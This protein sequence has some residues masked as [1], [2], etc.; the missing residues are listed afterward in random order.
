M[1]LLNIVTI[2]DIHLGILDPEY[3][4][5]NLKDYFF[6]YCSENKPDIIVV[7][8]DITDE[9]VS[10]NSTTASVFHMFI[11]ELVKLDTIIVIV[12]GTL[13]HDDNQINIFSHRICDKFRIYSKCTS[14][15]ILGLKMLFIP[16]EY[17][18][19]PDEYYKEFLDDKNSYDCVFGHGMFNHIAFYNKKKNIFRKLT[20]PMWDYV[21][22]FKNIVKGFVNFGH[23]HTHSTLDKLD[24]NGSFGRYNH[25]EEEPKGF[26]DYV[27][28]SEKRSVISKEFIVNEGAKVFKS[29]LESRLPISRDL[30]MDRLNEEY[31]SSFKLRIVLDR[32]ISDER[33]SDIMGFCKNNYNSTVYKKFE[34]KNNLKET[35]ST[36]TG[37][38][39]VHNKYEDMD[40]IDATIEFI[41]EKHGIK[42][43]RNHIHKLLNGEDNS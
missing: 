1:S 43:D 19:D 30:L 18:H 31:S 22:H 4:W 36:L 33:K 9:R 32:D 42:I 20:S 27:Y 13:S 6:K 25:G 5:D 24:Y 3:M 29:I 41:V 16:E 35:P 40:M 34:K 10:L 39:M 2:S 17:M 28:D 7:V 14:D 38:E 11:D 23:V 8:G 21:K 15:T 26:I 12:T 37:S